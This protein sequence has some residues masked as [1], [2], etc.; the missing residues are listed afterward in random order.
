MHHKMKLAARIASEPG[1][2]PA[3]P[4]IQNRIRE[5]NLMERIVLF[6][7]LIAALNRTARNKIAH[8]TA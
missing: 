8:S 1:N 5:K 3:L 2:R 4:R 6:V 7:A